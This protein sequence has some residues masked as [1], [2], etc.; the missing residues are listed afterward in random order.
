MSIYI[1]LVITLVKIGS[2]KLI[3][4]GKLNVQVQLILH[5][6]FLYWYIKFR[7]S[8]IFEMQLCQPFQ[9]VNIYMCVLCTPLTLQLQEF[10]GTVW[11]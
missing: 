8:D 3:F 2:S 11:L 10:H 1:S 7:V 9:A 5:F 6:K 4:V